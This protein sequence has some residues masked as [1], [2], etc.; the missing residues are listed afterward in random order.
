MQTNLFADAPT[1]DDRYTWSQVQGVTNNFHYALLDDGEPTRY[2]V[3]YRIKPS[4]T[5]WFVVT[6]MGVYPEDFASLP[7]AQE[8]V[9]SIKRGGHRR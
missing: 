7:D 2:W 9:M 3:R 5:P 4:I 6:P 1:G 8:K